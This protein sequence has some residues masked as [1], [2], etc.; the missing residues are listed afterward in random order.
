M[1]RMFQR[2]RHHII[3]LVP[4]TSVTTTYIYI[5]IQFILPILPMTGSLLL[6]SRCAGK[7]VGNMTDSLSVAAFYASLPMI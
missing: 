2:E 7:M 1:G 6:S 3:T 5:L 4:Y